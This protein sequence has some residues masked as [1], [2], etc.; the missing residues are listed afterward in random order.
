MPAVFLVLQN[1]SQS[2]IF[3]SISI[4]LQKSTQC[5]DYFSKKEIWAFL[6]EYIMIV[7]MIIH[8]LKS[9]NLETYSITTNK[10][11]NVEKGLLIIHMDMVLDMP[12]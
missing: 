12:Y 4:F 8:I 11:I 9:S 7:C 1:P 2:I 10:S 5:D 3:V 6:Q